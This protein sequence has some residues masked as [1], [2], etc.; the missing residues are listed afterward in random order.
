M[1]IANPDGVL[2]DD[3]APA[4]LPACLTLP[5]AAPVSVAVK[6]V[7]HAPSSRQ[8]MSPQARDVLLRAIAKAR[9][10][11]DDLA[12]GRVSSFAEIAEREAKVARHVRFLTP[13]A[14]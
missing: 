12:T 8:S 4:R 6:G 11:V 2:P 3:A 9:S 1:P 7:L 5:W 13:L 10:W 14:F